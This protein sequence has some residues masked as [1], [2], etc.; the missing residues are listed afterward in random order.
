MR[1]IKGY[2]G[3]YAAT[4]DGRIWSYR[5][6]KFLKPGTDGKGYKLVILCKD[7]KRKTYRIHRLVAETFLPNPANL[8]QINHIDENKANNALSNLEWISLKDNINFGTRTE[9]S[10]KA[11]QKKIICVETGEI[12]NSLTEAAIKNNVNKSA[13]CKACK[14]KLKTCA[15]YH[16]AYYY[17]DEE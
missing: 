16:W 12:F 7:K 11:R 13:I 4:E 5:S 6:K 15:G 17:E 10:A 8:P 2:E 1:D 3:L 14:G 9:R